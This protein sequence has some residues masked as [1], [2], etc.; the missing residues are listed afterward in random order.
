MR[1]ESKTKYMNNMKSIKLFSAIAICVSLLSSCGQEFSNTTGT[2]Y[3]DPKT[4][5]FEKMEFVDQE[6]GPG[7]VFVEGGTFTM[8]RAEQDVMFD[9]NNR[10]SRVTVSSFYS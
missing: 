2:A 9:W 4:G 7:L 10:P 3:N 8:G 6:T 1:I 5:G